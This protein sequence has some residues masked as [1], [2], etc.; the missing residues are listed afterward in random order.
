MLQQ[1][2][3]SQKSQSQNISEGCVSGKWQFITAFKILMLTTK[4]RFCHICGCFNPER[5]SKGHL[6]TLEMFAD[7]VRTDL[8]GEW[9]VKG[10]LFLA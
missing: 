7:G 5:N 3:V 6:E 8:L 10:S 1:S 4:G 2:H 9:P